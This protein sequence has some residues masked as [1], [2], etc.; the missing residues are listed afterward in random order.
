MMVA[1][2]GVSALTAVRIQRRSAEGWNDLIQARCHARS[3]IEM[4]LHSIDGDSDWRTNFANGTWLADQPIGAGTFC[5]EGIDP[6]DADLADSA[7]DALVLIGTGSQGE[8]RHKTQVTL[9]AIPEPLEA[10]NTCVHAAGQLWING[11][12]SLTVNDA[13]ASTNANLQNDEILD[14]NVEAVSISNL[15]VVTGTVTTPV[16]PKDLPDPEVITDYTA[17]ASVLPFPGNIDGQVLGASYNP[18][19][20]ANPYGAY[21]VDTGGSDWTITD[22][23]IH[24]TLIISCPGN[25]VVINDHALLHSY[26]ADY[27]TLIVDGNLEIRLTS[28]PE[29]LSESIKSVNFNPSGVPYLGGFDTDQT[30]EYP[31]EIQGLVHVT[32]T[33]AVFNPSRIRGVI[34]CESTVTID[35][36]CVITHD[37][38]LYE[39]PPIGYTTEVKMAIAEGSWKRAAD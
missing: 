1:V 31:N 24:G 6:M 18:W 17:R 4:G 11:G 7:S 19:G 10:L 26:R 22:S 2:I 28:A 38:S 13:P 33:V 15:G 23:R 27:P 8:A 36:K 37:S 35:G 39:D 34:I 5:L 9:V 25:K 21:F 16:P 30:D 14:G 20:P 29:R 32:G 3:A 12:D